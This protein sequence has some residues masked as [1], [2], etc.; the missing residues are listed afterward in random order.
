MV[1]VARGFDAATM[2]EIASRA[3]APIGSLYQFFPTKESLAAALH[4]DLLEVLGEMLDELQ[5]RAA[6][7]EMTV[8]ELAQ[9]MFRRLAEFLDLYPE[10][11]VLL[12]RRPL[13]KESRRATR[14]RIQRHVVALFSQ[15]SPP[16]RRR[17]AEVL[18]VLVI[19][20]MKVQLTL[21]NDSDEEMRGA[22]LAELRRMLRVYL[23]SAPFF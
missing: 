14:E 2:T 16:L 12:E 5:E 8:A 23:E 1:F 15:A 22:A 18:A 7:R 6:E 17:R 13:D 20:L 19:E 4:G 3:R 10:F 21:S 11:I 9:R